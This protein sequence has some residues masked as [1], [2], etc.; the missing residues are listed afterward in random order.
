MAA[1]SRSARFC[2]NFKLDSV[3][4]NKVCKT[5]KFSTSPVS[6]V[7]E[8][9][10]MFPAQMGKMLPDGTFDGKIAFITGGGTGLGKGMATML[11]RLGAQV[12]ISSR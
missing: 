10:K 5:K 1:P 8:H 7:K 12:V 2:L 9:S 3:L 6:H 4:W 11:S